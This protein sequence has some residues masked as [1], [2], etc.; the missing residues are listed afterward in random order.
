MNLYIQ[1]KVAYDMYK[2]SK[3]NSEKEYY[4]EELEKI[5]N[6]INNR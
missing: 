3:S 4:K 2:S 1:E 6:K 5:R